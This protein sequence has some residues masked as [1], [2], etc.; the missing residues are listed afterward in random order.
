MIFPSA[1]E[2]EGRASRRVCRRHTSWC[3]ALGYG[4]TK[5][6]KKNDVPDD[7]PTDK[8]WHD[9]ICGFPKFFHFQNVTVF[10]MFYFCD[11]FSEFFKNFWL[12]FMT[13]QGLMYFL[14]H[15]SSIFLFD[16]DYSSKW[17][18]PSALWPR[19]F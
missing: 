4:T 7:V 19:V 5:W 14:F 16:I 10:W 3:E 18:G 6:R 1:S 8:K 15:I 9:I 11:H 13:K 17:T 12:D 2:A